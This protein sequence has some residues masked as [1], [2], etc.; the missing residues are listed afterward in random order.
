ML[1]LS[2]EEVIHFAKSGN[3]MV[4]IVEIS[5]IVQT[6]VTYKVRFVCHYDQICVTIRFCLLSLDQNHVAG[7]VSSTTQHWRP[8]TGSHHQHQCG[9]GSGQQ[10]AG[11]PQ[12]R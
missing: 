5:N 11:Q 7:K 9:A 4:G 3:E 2:P 10:F 12:Q 6:P 8:C 1:R